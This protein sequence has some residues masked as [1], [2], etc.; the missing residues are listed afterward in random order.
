MQLI[1]GIHNINR[2]QRG[3]VL[4]IGNF[5]G[6]HLGHQAVLA[7]VKQQALQRGVPATVMTFEPQPQELF[8]PERAPARLTNF[9][10]KHL[11]LRSQGIDRHIVIEFNRQFA[12]QPACEFIEN[13]LVDLLG[14]Q[15]LVVGD[16]F[17]FGRGREGDFK[18]LQEAGIEFGFDVVDTHSYRQ[19]QHRVSSTAI[20]EFLKAGDFPSAAAMLGRPYSLS[21]RVAHGEKKGRT[22]GFPTANLQLKRL[23]SPLQGVYAVQVKIEN[24]MHLGVANIGRRPTVSGDRVQLEVHL[25]DFAES[26]YGQHIE[27]T[28]LHFIRAE[29]KFSDFNALREQITKDVTAAKQLLSEQVTVNR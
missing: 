23:H 15:F 6:V 12:S 16:D 14:V 28:P 20:R 7:Q 4:T 10:E 5:D 11:A 8:Q 9:R 27:V 25:F 26:I 2:D 21:G 17:R 13:V 18:L 19:Q 29:H 24:Q 1:R 3:C 22:I